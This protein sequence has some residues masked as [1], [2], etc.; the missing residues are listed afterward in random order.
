MHYT[1]STPRTKTKTNILFITKYKKKKLKMYLS[2]GAF[3]RCIMQQQA[4]N[5]SQE[6]AYL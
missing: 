2:F 5:K 3:G 6:C 4:I 1:S